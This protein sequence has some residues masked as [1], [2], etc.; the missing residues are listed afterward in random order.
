MGQRLF[1]LCRWISHIVN[2]LSHVKSVTVNNPEVN[3]L[4]Q[5]E[6]V[7]DVTYNIVLPMYINSTIQYVVLSELL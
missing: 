5:N 1:K 6:T 2:N 7:V 3:L 4:F